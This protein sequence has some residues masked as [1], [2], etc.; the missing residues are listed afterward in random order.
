MELP[1]GTLLAIWRPTKTRFTIQEHQTK[2]KWEGL[3]QELNIS[4]N[5][6]SLFCVNEWY[7]LD[8]SLREAKSIKYIKS[9]FK[10]IVNLKQKSLFPIHDPVGIKLLS[11]L[12][13]KLSHLSEH[14]FRHNFKD[15]PSPTCDC[16]WESETTDHF[17][18]R[19]P[20]FPEIDKN[21]YIACLR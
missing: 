12:Q 19:C 14:K 7:K 20:C 6:F 8:S 11:R 18:L 1:Q 5:S 17:F 3:G 13:L 10:E 16:G 2:T 4:N 21:S 9:R 15:A